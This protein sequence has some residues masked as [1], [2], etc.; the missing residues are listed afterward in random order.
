[1]TVEEYD[2]F[3]LEKK[4]GRFRRTGKWEGT[5]KGIAHECSDPEC[6]RTWKPLPMQCLTDDY[7]CPPCALHRRN[8]MNRFSDERLKW[9]ADVPNTF[10]LFSLV[11][12]GIEVKGKNEG[13]LIKFGRT[14]HKNALKRYPRAELKQYQMKLLLSL[15]GKLITRTRIE[16][17]W[18]EQAKEKNSD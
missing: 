10:Y 4:D 7:Y 17:W 13:S 14:Q 8:N 6:A 3:L 15:R 11:D 18:K 5:H 16:N 2:K 9:T 1:M 12:P